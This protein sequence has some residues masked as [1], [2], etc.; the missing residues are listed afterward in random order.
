MALIGLPLGASFRVRGRN[1]ALIMGLGVFILYYVMFSLG[2]SLAESGVVPP[3]PAVWFS[4][5][6]L[7]VLGLLMLRRINKGVPV[8]PLE[9]LRRFLTGT[10]KPR[11]TSRVKTS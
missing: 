7:A 8:D 6:V 5:V 3:A 2:W 9:L 4:N 11:S 1:F 10:G